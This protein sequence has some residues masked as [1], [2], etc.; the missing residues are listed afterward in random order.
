MINLIYFLEVFCK[1]LNKRLK[2][3]DLRPDY[4]NHLMHFKIMHPTFDINCDYTM[5]QQHLFVNSL[6]SQFAR[7]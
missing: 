5:I 4:V 2:L 1:V 3:C 7:Y 6:L